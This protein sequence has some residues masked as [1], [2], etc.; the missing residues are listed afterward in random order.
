MKSTKVF[1][2][3]FH[4]TGTS[5]LASALRILGYRV[6]GTFGI[7]DADIG[8][9][10]SKQALRIARD[11]DAAQDNPWPIVYQDLDRAYPHSKFILTTRDSDEWLA[12]VVRHFGGESTPMREWIYG[13]GDP[14]GNEAIYKKRYEEHNREVLEYFENRQN[15]LL[16]LPITEGAG[17]AQLCPFLG[18]EEPASEFPHSNS[19]RDRRIDRTILRK[20]RTLRVRR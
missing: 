1:G 18:L 19:H 11:W 3:G 16:V 15:D 13:V 14:V 12:S 7:D 5:T 4:K 2:I 20:L 8:L 17:W 9:T 6:A 10:A